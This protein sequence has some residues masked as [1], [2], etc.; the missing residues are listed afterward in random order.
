MTD[1]LLLGIDLG[2]TQVKTGLYDAQ[3]NEYGFS[4][5]QLS[6]PVRDAEGR[7]EQ[8]P[9][10]WWVAC[11]RAIRQCVGS[12]DASRVR[13]MCVGGQGPTLVAV[14][15]EG[16]PVR[17]A[18]LYD[19]RRAAKEAVEISE[20]LGR[21][22]SLRSSYLPRVVWIWKQDPVSFRST[23]WFLQAWDFLVYRLTGTA[24]TT[25]PSV[26]AYIPWQ[27]EDLAMLGLEPSL[28]PGRVETGERVASL[29]TE[30]A[31]ELGLPEGALVVAGG[32]DFL[33]GTMG[34]AGAQKGV[35]QSQGGATGALTLCWDRPLRG[36]MIGWSIRSPID[37]ALFNTGGPLTT[38]GAALDWL[39]QSVLYWDDP[40][41]ALE[42][43]AQVASGSEGLLFFPY[44]AGERLLDRAADR[45]VFLG[46][47]LQHGAAHLIRAVLEGVALAGRD[48]LE[49][50][51]D[52]GGRVDRVVTYGGQA[53]SSLWNQIKADVW[54]RPVEI[55]RVVDAGCLGAAA[56]AATGLGIYPTLSEAS[57]QMARVGCT[58]VPDAD[59][60]GLY[61][62]A[63]SIYQEIG[64]RNRDLF[65]RLAA[66]RGR[67][68]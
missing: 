21:A 60:L 7:S 31:A 65:V 34:V 45:G 27:D 16:A 55:P 12:A 32:N 48:I 57:Q 18:I 15:A 61:E 13:A 42:E 51:V 47:S 4:R 25:A 52:G 24:A 46:L 41:E 53:R 38:G 5:A 17:S 56:I 62:E 50:L 59:R 63:Y 9:E 29:S 49:S 28:F 58:F 26:D 8:D 6:P 37:P 54:N 36:E 2:T 44:L 68:G 23:R 35:A 20:R 14:D 43:A 11:C 30:A 33:F 22:V 10:N 19:D 40:E 1:G 66:L 39:L 3:G 64:L 67:R